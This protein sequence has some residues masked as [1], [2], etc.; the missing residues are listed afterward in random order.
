[1]K[2][3]IYAAIILAAAAFDLQPAQAQVGHGRWC[4]VISVGTGAVY[5]DCQYNTIEQCVPNVLAGNRG[6]CNYNPG[7]VEA[8]P[9]EM[10][11]HKHRKHPT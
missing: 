6:F 3:L 5:W 7:F 2:H 4:A 1:M 11:A 9:A 8:S 10:R